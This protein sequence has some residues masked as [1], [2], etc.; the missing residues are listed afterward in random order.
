MMTAELAL[1]KSRV[2]AKMRE[3]RST[4]ERSSRSRERYRA[5]EE[6]VGLIDQ[7]AAQGVPD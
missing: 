5:F 2:E 7:I 4:M 3:A 1:L 6:T